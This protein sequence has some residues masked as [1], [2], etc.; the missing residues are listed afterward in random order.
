MDTLT[1]PPPIPAALPPPAPAPSAPPLAA[2]APAA[3]PV[4]RINPAIKKVSS[5]PP[6]A[7]EEAADVELNED[8][9]VPGAELTGAQVS[10]IRHKANLLRQKKIR[11]E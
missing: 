11:G 5:K 2:P 4:T 10:E 8:G 9:F 3:P 1:P 6:V 7:V